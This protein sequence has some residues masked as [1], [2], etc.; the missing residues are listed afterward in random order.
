MILISLLVTGLFWVCCLCGFFLANVGLSHFPRKLSNSSNFSNLLVFHKMCSQYYFIT[1]WKSVV[2]IIFLF[3]SV[4][5]YYI[6]FFFKQPCQR[7][8]YFVNL[9]KRPTCSLAKLLCFLIVICYSFI[10][11]FVAIIS[12][13]FFRLTLS[14]LSQPLEIS[15]SSFVFCLLINGFRAILFSKVLLYPKKL[16]CGLFIQF[17]LHISQLPFSFLL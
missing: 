14:P 8:S 5:Y 12:S 17:V 11:A 3:H 9:S 7:F 10:S 16:A 1:F 6:S 4:L 13:F 2:P 15:L